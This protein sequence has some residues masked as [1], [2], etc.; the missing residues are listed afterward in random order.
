MIKAHV[1][2]TTT[3][4]PFIRHLGQTSCGGTFFWS[5]GMGYQCYYTHHW[6]SQNIVITLTQRARL[7]AVPYGVPSGYSTYGRGP[8][9]KR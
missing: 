2:K 1:P 9:V 3:T 5:P 8:L 7:G 4:L 6:S